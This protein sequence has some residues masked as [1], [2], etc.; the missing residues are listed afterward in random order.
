MVAYTDDM[1]KDQV[2]RAVATRWLLGLTWGLA[3]AAAVCLLELQAASTS[4]QILVGG[5]GGLLLAVI[6]YCWLFAFSTQ[7]IALAKPTWQLVLELSVCFALGLL[8]AT[9]YPYMPPYHED[10]RIIASGE[11]NPEAKSGE[12]WLRSFGWSDGQALPMT[13]F[14]LDKAWEYREGKPLSY[15]N[16]PGELRWSGNVRRWNVFDLNQDLIEWGSTDGVPVQLAPQA[17]QRRTVSDLELCFLAHP[18]SGKV[19]ILS[20]N[21][22][23]TLDLY[24]PSQTERCVKIPVIGNPDASVLA[25]PIIVRLIAGLSLGLLLFSIFGAP[26]QSLARVDHQAAGGSPANTHRRALFKPTVLLVLGGIIVSVGATAILWKWGLS[27]IVYPN[28]KLIIDAVASGTDYLPI[29]IDPKVGE[30]VDIPLNWYDHE[31]R[32]EWIDEAGN[33]PVAFGGIA[34]G[35]GRQ[36]SP[37]ALRLEPHPS[38]P[39]EERGPPPG[40]SDPNN[41]RWNELHRVPRCDFGAIWMGPGGISSFDFAQK[42]EAANAIFFVPEGRPKIKLTIDGVTQIIT[43]KTP[44]NRPGEVRIP[45]LPQRS[46]DQLIR[47]EV[48]LPTVRLRQFCLAELPDGA[49]CKIG[50]VQVSVPGLA[51]IEPA[52]DSAVT[53]ATCPPGSTPL[54]GTCYYSLEVKLLSVFV[55]LLISAC[56]FFA[57][58]CGYRLIGTVSSADLKREPIAAWEWALLIVCLLLSLWLQTGTCGWYTGDGQ[59]YTSQAITFVEQGQFDTKIDG[60][61][62]GYTTFLAAIF[63]TGAKGAG[64][65]AVNTVFLLMGISGAWLLGRWF[66][67]RAGGALAA[68]VI[69]THPVILVGSRVVLPDFLCSILI[70]GWFAL[71]VRWALSQPK[72]GW[73]LALAAGL[74]CTALASIRINA[75]SLLGIGLVV[76]L[77]QRGSWRWRIVGGLCFLVIGGAAYQGLKVGHSS[78]KLL[79]A[80]RLWPVVRHRFVAFDSAEFRPLRED[81]LR[82]KCRLGIWSFRR[83]YDNVYEHDVGYPADDFKDTVRAS[84]RRNPRRAGWALLSCLHD[85]YIRTS[86]AQLYAMAGAYVDREKYDYFYTRRLELYNGDKHGLNLRTKEYLASYRTAFPEGSIPHAVFRWWLVNSRAWRLWPITALALI[87]LIYA[88][89]T[90]RGVLALPTAVNLGLVLP[91]ALLFTY[92]DRYFLPGEPL[93]LLQAAVGLRALGEWGSS[94][95]TRWRTLLASPLTPEP[96][97]IHN[98]G[99]PRSST[100]STSTGNS[101]P[102]DGGILYIVHEYPPIVGGAGQLVHDLVAEVSKHERV[103]VLTASENDTSKTEQHGNIDLVKLSIP[104]RHKVYHYATAKSLLVFV[105]KAIW[106]GWRIARKRRVRAIHAYYVFPGGLIGAVLSK[107]LGIPCFITAVGAEIHDPSKQ[108]TLYTKWYYKA[109][110]GAIMAQATKLS[111]ISGDIARRSADYYRPKPISILPPGIPDPLNIPARKEPDEFVICSLSRLAPRKGLELI[112]EALADLKNLPIR[113]IAMGDGHSRPSL[114]ALATELGVRERIDF[115]GFVSEE[116]KYAILTSSS[117]FVLPSLHEGFGI[118]YIEAMAAGLPIVAHSIGGQTDFI[119]DGVNGLLLPERTR[120]NLSAALLRLYNDPEW[121]QEMGRTNIEKAKAYYTRNLVSAYLSHYNVVYAAAH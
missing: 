81:W 40:E 76:P 73:W 113:Y 119:A 36:Y 85:A 94:A 22:K 56:V 108:T 10:I 32:C 18:W 93:L 44:G 107:L 68:I 8:I 60:H 24:A 88:L 83:F 21:Q 90:R 7:S 103:I 96:K 42:Y 77:L 80:G 62:P 67:G 9:R 63:A 51:Q 37:P 79:A 99:R 69:S 116:E 57:I 45:L 54:T 31:V 30:V 111:A 50:R 102:A 46:P 110:L 12:V 101:C 109:A 6:G 95:W 106:S 17:I 84:I 66:A 35:Q 48:S 43:L 121:R 19:T 71:V 25:H 39:P 92:Y 78:N 26:S 114:E 23:K 87:G 29:I 74:T 61:P 72:S 11:R 58:W 70:L 64:L 15:Q 97:Y 120:T 115:R 47:Y 91:L 100:A 55:F 49:T 59:E 52:S 16:Q 4:V 112:V 118:C 3:T 89:I 65:W 14:I 53:S 117:V 2:S 34:T 13:D 98:T 28:G 1:D 82:A 105:A 5:F 104:F 38:V 20:G 41:P 86:V 33:P 75:I 27:N